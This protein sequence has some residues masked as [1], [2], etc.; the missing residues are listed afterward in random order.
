M[1]IR[2]VYDTPMLVPR[3]EVVPALVIN[4]HNPPPWL[5]NSTAQPQIIYV[6]QQQNYIQ[7]QPQQQN[8]VQ[9]LDQNQIYLQQ[10]AYQNPQMFLQNY[11]QMRQ[12]QII[13][14]V[15]QIPNP[16]PNDPNRMLTQTFV[17]TQPNIIQNTVPL[18]NQVPMPVV[19]TQSQVV[20][21]KIDPNLQKVKDNRVQ[22]VQ[23]NQPTQEIQYQ[24]SPNNI[25]YVPRPIQ[26]LRPRM[27]RPQMSQSPQQQR[28]A[29]RNVRPQRFAYRPIQP[30]LRY[31]V[32]NVSVQKRFVQSSTTP[33]VINVSNIVGSPSLNSP[34][35]GSIPANVGR[36]PT[37]NVGPNPMT[38]VANPINT[39]NVGTVPAN[40]NIN[41][42]P[43]NA[44]I[45]APTV[46]NT[47]ANNL[48]NTKLF[49]VQST[50]TTNSTSVPANIHVA[51]APTTTNLV[52]IIPPNL[53]QLT[54]NVNVVPINNVL[55]PMIPNSLTSMTS[56]SPIEN[57]VNRKRK[58][59]SPD[60]IQNKLNVLAINNNPVL[61]SH[62]STVNNV[63][64]NC[65]NDSK[66][67]DKSVSN[68]VQKED[69]ESYKTNSTHG[70]VNQIN[71]AQS[72]L[73]EKLVRNTVFTQARGRILNVKNEI[74]E[75]T[76]S[77]EI[78]TELVEPK[79]N[80]PTKMVEVVKTEDKK[81]AL[82][83]LIEEENDKNIRKV[84]KGINKS[85]VNDEMKLTD[86]D[87]VLTH[88]LDGFV[89]QESN[90]AFPIRKPT[91]ER[92]IRLSSEAPE[93]NPL[94]EKDLEDEIPS[95]AIVV[96]DRVLPKE[97]N[98][99]K[100]T[101]STNTGY[102]ETR[103]KENTKIAKSAVVN[104]GTGNNNSSKKVKENNT[105]TKSKNSRRVKLSERADTETKPT[106]VASTSFRE[107]IST[108]KSENSAVEES[109]P[110]TQESANGIEKDFL[111]P[112]A[113]LKP[114][115]V[116]T[117]PMSQLV[118]HL[119][120]HGWKETSGALF[121]HEIDGESLQ[122]VSKSQ[123]MTIGVKEEHAEVI[124]EFM[125]S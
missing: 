104:E 63:T 22:N 110:S 31:Q 43:P 28:P 116:K 19:P 107:D 120:D 103:S 69:L 30:R 119:S 102:M 89:I 75:E 64:D 32:P 29:V 38:I 109:S 92:T 99:D 121:E 39:N 106:E 55:G 93:L 60:E 73:K 8:Y 111:N 1:S 87:F 21:D 90:I 59:E 79:V 80:E 11:D 58:S 71:L 57:K 20:P 97:K 74:K 46:G 48:T 7:Q 40:N 86:K 98:T 117:W 49:G 91:I 66:I 44:N 61:V 2:V 5:Q 35:T 94:E 9:Q 78:Q 36:V 56:I 101:K 108:N 51:S 16:D 15:V 34:T 115:D 33:N 118:K 77:M 70:L 23:V 37:G 84:N 76:T 41:V 53:Q 112:F 82:N 42:Q 14:N 54:N 4:P 62:L 18:Q 67:N 124:M 27:A 100:G 72:Q 13:P 83:S 105:R 85:D 81:E 95:I 26:Q 122:L 114:S 47:I 24:Q 52:N 125:N 25:Q 3:D 17:Q 68:E 12:I 113:N 50:N 96:K 10:Y 45:L 88:V 6:Q 65:N 123:L